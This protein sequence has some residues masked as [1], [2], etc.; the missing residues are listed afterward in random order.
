MGCKHYFVPKSSDDLNGMEG[1]V[2]AFTFVNMFNVRNSLQVYIE[3]EK[4]ER[5]GKEIC[6]AVLFLCVYLLS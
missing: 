5:I 6:L 2:L 3:C 4:K 1:R